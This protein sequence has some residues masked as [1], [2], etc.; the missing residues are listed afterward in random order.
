[1]VVALVLLEIGLLATAGMI[2][3]AQRVLS[4]AT[5]LQRGIQEGFRSADSLREN[6]WSAEGRR[7]FQGGSVSWIPAT[8]GF[9]GVR[10][11]ALGPQG[12]TLVRFRAWSL[13]EPRESHGLPSGSGEG[14]G[15]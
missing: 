3:S 5:L 7:M 13:D 12:D 1:V 14:V 10:I 9:G 8:D 11:F 6:G 4:R 2:F 15:R